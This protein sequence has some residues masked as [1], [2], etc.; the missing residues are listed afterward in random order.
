MKINAL[1]L[2]LLL[3]TSALAQKVLVV[4]PH[5][6]DDVLGCGG[7]IIHHVRRGDEVMTVYL[8]SGEKGG[9]R[10]PDEE[11]ARGL[12]RE[13]EG[14][15][16]SQVLGVQRTMFLRLPDSKVQVDKNTVW[17][18]ELLINTERP[19]VIYT[20]HDQDTH[21]DHEAAGRLVY[22]AVRNINLR[23]NSYKP[24]VR[25]CEIWG[26]LRRA[27]YFEDITDVMEMKM[28]ALS[29]H[30]SQL[31][32]IHYDEAIK[33]LNHYRACMQGHFVGIGKGYAEAF[34]EWQV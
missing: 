1:L 12:L 20:T 19:A 17:L 25:F 16:A 14:R 11:Q 18:L 7:S 4:A 34:D 24:V 6:D 26:P 29:Y 28:H 15:E 27:N 22:E 10:S 8:T 5:P 9:V 31:A 30:R 13:Q 2:S 3:C 23:D 33:G 21:K 32:D